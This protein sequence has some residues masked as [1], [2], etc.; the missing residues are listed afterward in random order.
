MAQS[1]ASAH[2]KTIDARL[3]RRVQAGLAAL[4]GLALF[5]GVAFAHPSLIHNAAHDARHGIAAPCH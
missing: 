3:G 1:S 2:V 4:L 5:L